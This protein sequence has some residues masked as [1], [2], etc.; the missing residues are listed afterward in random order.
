MTIHRIFTLVTGGLLAGC[1]ATA[2]AA[3]DAPALPKS[4]KKLTKQ[5]ILALYDGK[6]ISFVSYQQDKPVVGTTTFDLHNMKST[7]TYNY[8]NGERSG[9]WDRKISFKG[10]QLCNLSQDDE[11]TNC[12][13][14]YASGTTSYA[15]I[16]SRV[17]AKSKL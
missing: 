16:G 15:V 4:A 8:N 6:T 13:F 17:I 3:G 14:V 11:R 1:L 10:D 2:A 7:G 5:E 9:R 12:Y